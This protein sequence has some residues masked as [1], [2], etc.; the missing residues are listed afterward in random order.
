MS[1][2]KLSDFSV[3]KIQ[4]NMKNKYAKQQIDI[5]VPMTIEFDEIEIDIEIKDIPINHWPERPMPSCQN[6]NDPRYYDPGETEEN[7]F[8]DP[9]DLEKQLREE[10]DRIIAGLK[11]NFEFQIENIGE[12]DIQELIPN[13]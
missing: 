4:L 8:E 12:I 10:F 1:D 3:K 7:E 5:D 13:E 2:L 9:N 11:N 6:P